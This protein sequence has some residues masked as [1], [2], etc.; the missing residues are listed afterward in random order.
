MRIISGSARG[1]ILYSPSD[2]RIRPTSDRA[3][4]GIF[5][6]LESEFGDLLDAQDLFACCIHF[7]VNVVATAFQ[8]V[9]MVFE[10]LTAYVCKLDV[11][12]KDSR[13]LEL[14]AVWNAFTA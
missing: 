2:E 3:R 13:T 8:C 12:D 5:S 7:Q 10:L 14:K 4:E 6:T 11:G 9:Q 1:K